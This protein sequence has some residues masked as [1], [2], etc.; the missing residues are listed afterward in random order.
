VGEIGLASMAPA[1]ANAIVQLENELINS[2]FNFDDL[3]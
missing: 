1:I 3:M 2:Q